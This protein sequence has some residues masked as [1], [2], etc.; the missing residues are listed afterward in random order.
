MYNICFKEIIPNNDL[1][2]ICNIR[3]YYF[4]NREDSLYF[5]V[6]ADEQHQFPFILLQ[7]S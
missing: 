7:Y 6:A 1:F 2:V 5:I 4:I 3:Q